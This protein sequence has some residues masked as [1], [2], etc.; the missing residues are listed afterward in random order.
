M[1]TITP[2]AL[3][4]DDW[5]AQSGTTIYQWTSVAPGDQ[6]LPIDVAVHSFISVQVSGVLDGGSVAIDGT[7]SEKSPY[8]P[9]HD[10]HGNDISIAS[11]PMGYDSV[12]ESVKDA[13]R[14]LK[15][16]LHGGGASLV[17][18]TILVRK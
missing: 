1:A 4:V 6:C 13:A 16:S 7:L 10:D 18:I 8:A 9:L 12:I 17:T 3:P 5:I 2:V 11:Y 14:K 15:P